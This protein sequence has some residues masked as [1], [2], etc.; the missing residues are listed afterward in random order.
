MQPSAHTYLVQVVEPNR[1][2]LAAPQ[3]GD[4]AQQRCEADLGEDNWSRVGRQMS[5][6]TTRPLLADGGM[7]TYT[8]LGIPALRG[9][10]GERGKSWVLGLKFPQ[11][12]LL[13]S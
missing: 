12:Q 11:R 3:H 7:L 9:A 10:E 13:R 1:D 4:L 6:C 5:R 2:G 8:R